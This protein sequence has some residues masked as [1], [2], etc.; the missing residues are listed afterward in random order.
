MSSRFG[1]R[2]T[3]EPCARRVPIARSLWPESSGATS[4]SSAA[5]VGREV[6]VHVGDDARVAAPTRRRAARGR[7]PC[8]RAAGT[9]RR[10]SSSRERGARSPAS[11]R[12]SRC[13]RS[14]SASVNGKPSRRKRCRRRMLRS[15]AGLLVVDGDDDV[16]V[17]RRARQERAGRAGRP[18]SRGRM[19]S[20]DQQSA[21]GVGAPWEQAES[22]L[23]TDAGAYAAG[24]RT[25]NDAPP[26]GA[27]AALDLAAVRVDDRRRRSRGRGRRRRLPRSRPPSA[28]QK[29]SNSALGSSVGQARAVVAH[30]EARRSPSARPTSTSIGVPGGRVD[31][32]V[33][34][35]VGEHL[36]QLV[37][38]AEDE[39][40][41][42]STRRSIVAVGRGRA[43]VVD[44][45]AR[46]A[47]RGRPRLCGASATSSSRASVSRS[48]TSTPMRAASSS[49]RRIAFSTSS[50][51]ARGAHP[52]QLG[53]AA[54]RRQRR[55]Q[56][57]RGVGEEAAQPV[58][59]RLALGERLLEAVE[60]RVQR[61][62]EAADL[63][64]RVGRLD[65]VREVAAGDRA[66]GVAHAVERQQADA[67]D[68]PRERRRAASSTPA[69]TSASTSSSRCERLVDV[70]Q[71]DRDDGRARSERAAL[72]EDAVAVAVA[73]LAVD[74]DRLAER[75]VRRA[76][77][78]VGRDARGRSRTRSASRRSCRRAS[79][80]SP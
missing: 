44:G 64:A 66:G 9:R 80:C 39:R 61:E 11:R 28:R 52:E 46:R 35:Q 55:A 37:G 33:A 36:A 56:L 22:P 13:R 60:H 50:R 73:V 71:R 59:A 48:S 78:G 74:G 76:A 10:G 27:F 29:R 75:D 15:S 2:T 72:G 43:R 69:I 54:D 21:R 40:A 53:V 31:E 23:R 70:A 58:L 26:P 19:R 12:C 62:P 57:V 16:D 30:L 20:W 6:D 18:A 17:A 38:V 67:H 1:P 45:V 79:R 25:T 34:Q 68:D 42:P 4:G 24:R 49:I 32:R 51:L 63:G 41:A 77:S 8:A 14:R 47:R 3:R 5:Q 7:G 65:A